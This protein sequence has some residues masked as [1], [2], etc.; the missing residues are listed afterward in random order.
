MARDSSGISFT[1]FYTG[2]VWRRHGLSVPF[3]AQPEGRL[4]YLAGRPME[5]LAEAVLGGGNETMLLQR[6]LIIDHLLEKAVTEEG[7]TQVVEIACGLSPRGTL[8]AKRFA[9]QDLHYIE[10]DLPGM[11]A[12]K[13]ALLAAAGELD[14]RHRVIDI[15]I[16]AQDVPISLEAVFGG[17]L[18]PAR[19]TLVITEGL[20]NYFDHPTITGFWTRLATVLE[21]F[22]AGTYLTDLYPNFQWHRSVRVA[23]VFK[24][25]LGLA[26]RSHV[27]LH[28]GN[29]EAI[30]AG[31]QDTGFAI[32]RVHLPESYYGVLPIPVQRTPSLVRVVENRVHAPALAAGAATLAG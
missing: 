11:A 21:E 16:L 7:F 17:Q 18:D 9:A 26:T 25:A 27:T 4:L 28:F 32:T 14:T 6:H 12:R 1:A 22:P 23:N 10:A 19:K 5:R 29:E 8:M 20:V 15:D 13:R 31:F 3:L 24:A 2:E 30:K